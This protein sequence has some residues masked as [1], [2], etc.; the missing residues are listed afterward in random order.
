MPSGQAGNSFGDVL[1]FVLPNTGLKAGVSHKQFRLF[2]GD[3]EMG[4]CLPADLD[5]TYQIWRQHRF[6]PNAEALL[7]LDHFA[8]D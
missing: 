6:G 3:A 8:R 1:R 4:A 7:A 2:P 5:L